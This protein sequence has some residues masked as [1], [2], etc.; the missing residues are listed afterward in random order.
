M[1]GEQSSPSQAMH[2][3][4]RA[5][6]GIA[7]AA[8]PKTATPCPDFESIWASAKASVASRGEPLCPRFHLAADIVTGPDC[9]Q[10]VVL[11]HD[12]IEL[13]FFASVLHMRG[14]QLVEQPVTTA[15]SC[16]IWNGELFD[17]QQVGS[18]RDV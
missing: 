14:R 13:R 16:L 4:L 5:L 9:F 8:R 11:P 2:D 15:T 10:E 17:G 6:Q 3:P 1:C 18:Q 7:F 12:G